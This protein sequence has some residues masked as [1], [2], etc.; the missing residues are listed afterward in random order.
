MVGSSLRRG[1]ACGNV[2]QAT[3][4]RDG[5]RS[6]STL[7]FTRRPAKRPRRFLSMLFSAVETSFVCLC[8]FRTGPGHEP[9]FLHHVTLVR[10]VLGV[11]LHRQ[12]L[13]WQPWQWVRMPA[14]NCAA[15]RTAGCTTT[16]SHSYSRTLCL[17]SCNLLA[18]LLRGTIA[19]HHTPA[20]TVTCFLQHAEN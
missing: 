6:G 8:E 14:P 11:P 10:H 2:H 4:G 5:R 9:C 13:P 15:S 16:Q 3:Q 17:T 1:A 7:G 12:Y 18:A 20:C 19:S